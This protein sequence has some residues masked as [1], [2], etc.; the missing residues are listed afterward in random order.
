MCVQRGG[1]A[2]ASRHAAQC[3]PEPSAD[4]PMPITGYVMDRDFRQ[5]ELKAGAVRVRLQLADALQAGTRHDTT[6]TA[7][8]VRA[9]DVVG[10][11]RQG[12]DRSAAQ[13]RDL[14][15]TPYRSATLLG[16]PSGFGHGVLTD[17]QAGAT[18]TRK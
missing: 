17:A 2:T 7:A 14:H 5:A 11:P 18:C 16:T 4:R 1:D 10:S 9:T 6:A 12:V 3:S 8:G 15:S 13:H